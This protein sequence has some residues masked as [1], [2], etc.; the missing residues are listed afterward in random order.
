VAAGVYLDRWLAVHGQPHLI[1]GRGGESVHAAC[2]DLA[3]ACPARTECVRA[4]ARVGCA[5]A[6]SEAHGLVSAR[7]FSSGKAHIV[8][9][10][11]VEA[12]NPRVIRSTLGIVVRFQLSALCLVG[13][14]SKVG[15][16]DPRDPNEPA[17]DPHMVADR[18]QNPGPVVVGP[19][20]LI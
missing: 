20:L 10:G 14:P 12:T 16:R 11:S 2:G 3:L 4:D 13:E 6:P 8:E 19:F 7:D 1:V 15:L 17:A 18:R 5:V 9:V